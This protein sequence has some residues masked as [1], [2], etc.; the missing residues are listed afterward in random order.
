MIRFSDIDRELQSRQDV[1]PKLHRRQEYPLE[2]P[3]TN[4]RRL[5][6]ACQH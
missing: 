1:L 6:L 3:N 2:E 5:V 4:H